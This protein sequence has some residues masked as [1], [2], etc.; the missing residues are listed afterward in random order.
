MMRRCISPA[1]VGEMYRLG[2]GNL[3]WEG[4]GSSY[5]RGGGGGRGAK[6][7]FTCTKYLLIKKRRGGGGFFSHA[8]GGGGGTQSFGVISTRGFHF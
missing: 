4:V 1:S 7:R 2:T 8:G 5:M 6:S 3:S